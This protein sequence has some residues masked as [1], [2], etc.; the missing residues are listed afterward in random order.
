MAEVVSTYHDRVRVD[1]FDIVPQQAGRVLDFG[2]GIGATS[3]ALKAAGRASHVVLADQV[4][5]TIAQGVDRAF[6][7]NLEDLDLIDDIIAQA[8]PFDTILALDILEHLRDPW[9][10]MRHLSKGVVPGGAMIISL[11]NVNHHSLVLPLLL[12]GRYDLRNAGVLD[13]THLRWFAKHGVIELATS[14]GLVLEAEQAN[15]FIR[16]HRRIDKLT[17]GLLTRFLALQYVV[18][19]RR[20]D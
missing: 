19:V 17:F 11:P 4:A 14:T 2:G 10:V 13:R 7:G 3:A 9:A 8:G 5:D 12:K 18:R 1:T 6:A 20:K 16:R 15:I